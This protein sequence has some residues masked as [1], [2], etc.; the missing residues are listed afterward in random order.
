MASAVGLD[1]KRGDT[2]E[3]KNIDFAQEDFDEATRIISEKERRSYVLNMTIYGLIGLIIVLFFMYVVK[4]FIRWITE[5]TIDSVDTFLPQTIE[6]LEKLQ[7]GG[8]IPILEENLPVIPEKVDPEKVEG[9]LLKEKITTL[10]DA[11]PHKAALILRDWLHL[12]KKKKEEEGAGA[13]GRSAT[14]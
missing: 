2:L 5:N 6:E 10:V 3:I 12:E 8:S 1:R 13:K 7:K 4:P 9:E 11:N 14:A